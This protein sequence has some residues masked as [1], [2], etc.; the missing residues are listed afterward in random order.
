MKTAIEAFDAIA[1]AAAQPNAEIR[2]ARDIDLG[3][4]AH[5]GDVYLHRV[6]AEWPRGKILGT[7]QIA[8]GATI[9]ARHIVEGEGVTVCAGKQYPEGFKEPED[10]DPKALLGPVV[11]VDGEGVLTHPEH[12]HHRLSGVYQVTYQYDPATHRSVRD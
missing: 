12:A 5:Q 10:C 9:G 3:K 7:R 8:V 11:I 6:P 2:D 4:V 1:K